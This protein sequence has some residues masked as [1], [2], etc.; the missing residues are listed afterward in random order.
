MFVYDMRA[1]VYNTIV[2]S[3]HTVDEEIAEMELSLKKGLEKS[4]KEMKGV[5]LV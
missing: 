3:V 1:R 2:V 5:S 4:E